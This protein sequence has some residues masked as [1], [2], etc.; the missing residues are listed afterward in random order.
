MQCIPEDSA[1][2]EIS[3]FEK[4]LT[5][6]RAIL[7]EELNKFIAVITI[8]DTTNVEVSIADMITDG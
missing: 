4:F 3:A 2:W 8:M 7:S 1:L 6:R 5:T